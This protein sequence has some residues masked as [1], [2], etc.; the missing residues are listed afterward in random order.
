[1]SFGTICYVGHELWRLQEAQAQQKKLQEKLKKAERA[2]AKRDKAGA[3]N[4][5]EKQPGK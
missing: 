3:L 5:M 2:E 4:R 1:M